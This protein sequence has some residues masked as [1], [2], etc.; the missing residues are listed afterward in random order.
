MQFVCNSIIKN[1]FF[2]FINHLH[3]KRKCF[4][5]FKYQENQPTFY[6][7][8]LTVPLKSLRISLTHSTVLQNF[9]TGV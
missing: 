9:H 6:P 1:V 7:V 5:Y 2:L 8:P 4:K 3:H